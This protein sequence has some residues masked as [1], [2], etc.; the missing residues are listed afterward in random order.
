MA[1]CNAM[2]WFIIDY[3]K[4]HARSAFV[5][6]TVI[7]FVGYLVLWSYWNG[8]NW[9]RILVLIE[10][11]VTIFNLHYWNASFATLLK[12]P[13]RIMIAS[14]AVLGI[15]LLFWLNTSTVRAFFKLGKT[16]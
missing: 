14:E 11:V 6:F 15:F 16:V 10:S 1:I 4:P 2:G 3:T 13:N 12:A 8:R 9:A 5:I 7:I